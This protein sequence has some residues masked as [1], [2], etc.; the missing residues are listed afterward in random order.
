MGK[1]NIKQLS[2]YIASVVVNAMITT[3]ILSLVLAI[4]LQGGCKKVEK[5]I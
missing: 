5:G 2:N 1:G 4:A 3:E